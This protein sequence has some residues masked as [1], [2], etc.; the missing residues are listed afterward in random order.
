MKKKILLLGGGHSN[1][2]VLHHLAKLDRS[3]FNLTLISDVLYSPYSGMLPSYLAGVYK[4]PD[5]HFDLKKICA[6]FG[7]EFIEDKVTYIN[8]LN[9]QALT[10][11]G[12]VF[13]FD[14]CS[15]NLGI[16]PTAVPAAEDPSDNIIYVKPISKFIIGWNQTI[17]FAESSL[18]GLHFSVIGGGAGAFEIAIACRR[19]FHSLD[20]K[21]SLIT[22]QG[23]LLPEHNLAAQQYARQSLIDLN[24][25]L[26]QGHRVELIEKNH[27]NLNDKR[28]IET[29]ICYVGTSAQAPD[30]F[31]LSGLPVNESGF[32]TVDENL[33]V[34]GLK[35]IFAAG[36][37]C[38]FTPR[39]LP[40]AGVFAVRQG[41]VLS[42]NI[43]ALIQEQ[44]KL[45]KYIPQAHFLTILVSGNNKAIASYKKFAFEGRLAWIL[46][47]Y[48]D[49][50]FMKRFS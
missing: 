24:I 32:V 27:L 35:N 13:D 19:K 31:K 14:I 12:R 48:I 3:L 38:H 37:C 43:T 33:L 41:P 25:E 9:N 45:A 39:P 4:G 47:D 26:I 22:G 15:I 10:A 18:K 1:L 17:H 21:I 23:G 20:H 28:Q 29:Q 8:Y 30:I 6:R 2:Q 34:S 42:K 5:L 36:D 46:K 40:K 49:R 11:T 50:K 44:K 7:F 16:Q